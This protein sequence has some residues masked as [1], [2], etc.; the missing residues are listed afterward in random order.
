MGI[1]IQLIAR[2][3]NMNRLPIISSIVIMYCLLGLIKSDARVAH[4]WAFKIKS[5]GREQVY[6]VSLATGHSHELTT[7]CEADDG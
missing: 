3:A 7:R 5:L 4:V 1:K 2:S 6:A